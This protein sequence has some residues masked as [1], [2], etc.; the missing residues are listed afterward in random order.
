MRQPVLLERHLYLFF[1]LE[2]K[3]F[4]GHFWKGIA[5]IRSDNHNHTMLVYADTEMD[6]KFCVMGVSLFIDTVKAL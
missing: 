4:S 1:A 2:L 6:C 3:M 5:F